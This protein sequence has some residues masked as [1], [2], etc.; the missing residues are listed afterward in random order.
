MIRLGET[1]ELEIVKIVDFGVYLACGQEKEERVLLPRKQ[2]PQDSKIG[3]K[4][5]VFIYRDSQDR[6]TA[7]VREP[8]L[9]MGDVAELTV[10]QIGSIGA[11]LDWGLEKDLF[12]PFR[13]QRGRV[14]QGQK[15]LVSLYVDKSDRLCATMNVYKNLKSD[16]PYQAG[17]Q[18]TGRV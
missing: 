8:L 14:E 10:A 3:D 5:R 16:S 18:V 17:D 15:V 4:I 13:Q 9:Q 6:M 11:F 12:L 7:T 1:Q 2:V